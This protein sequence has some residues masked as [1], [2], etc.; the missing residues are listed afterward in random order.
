ME[1]KKLSESIKKIVAAK[2]DYKCA[3]FLG[4]NVI[5]NYNCIYHKSRGGTFDEAGYEIDHIKEYCKTHNNKM[6]N[7]Q[8]L[9]LPCHRVKTIRFNQQKKKIKKE[10]TIIHWSFKVRINKSIKNSNE[11]INLCKKDKSIGIDF[12]IKK[13][14]SLDKIDDYPLSIRH[15]IKY[16]F[17]MKKNDV[18]YFMVDSKKIVAYAEIADTEPYIDKE[19]KKKFIK[20]DQCV[21]RRR[22][23][24][25]KKIEIE[26]PKMRKNYITKEKNNII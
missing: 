14:I 10:S 16:F 21:L 6:N 1:K 22:I 12:N 20:G 9:C 18:I 26:N 17:D 25:F 8:A 19:F 4:S 24:N 23:K 3:N 5:P 13:K 11:I 7:L 15:Q 2:Q